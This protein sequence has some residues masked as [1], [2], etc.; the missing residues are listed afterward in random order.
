MQSYSTISVPDSLRRA[1]GVRLG[2]PSARWMIEL[3]AR[4]LGTESELV[5]KSRRVVP[6]RLLD[7]GFVFEYP[8]WPAAA[9]ELVGRRTES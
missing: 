2:L 7:S 5:L 9:A 1:W 4:V 6:K 8:E 3:G